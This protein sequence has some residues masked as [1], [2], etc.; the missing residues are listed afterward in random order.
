MNAKRQVPQPIKEI[1]SMTEVE[2]Y[3]RPKD[4]CLLLGM[5]LSTFWRKVKNDEAFPKPVKDGRRSLISASE[6][7]AYQTRLIRRSE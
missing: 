1:K 2:R 5:S 4:V 6:L 7:I 3:L